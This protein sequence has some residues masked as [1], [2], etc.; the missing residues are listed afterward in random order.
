MPVGYKHRRWQA[1]L[2]ISASGPEFAPIFEEAGRA[3]RPRMA[4]DLRYTTADTDFLERHFREPNYDSGELEIHRRLR[5]PT[6]GDVGTALQDVLEWFRSHRDH[7][8]WDG[9]ALQLTF[10][11][12]GSEPDG[13]LVLADGELTP[14]YLIEESL[15]IAADASRSARLRLSLIL[16]SCHSGA[17][18]AKALEASLGNDVLVPF[19][20]VASCARDEFAWEESSL[21]HGIFTYCLSVRPNSLGSVSA[22]AIQANNSLGPSLSIAAGRFG[23]SLLTAGGQNPFYYLNGTGHIEVGGSEFSAFHEDGKP[24]ALEELEEQLLYHRESYAN[25]IRAIRPDLHM[26]RSSDAEMRRGIRRLR[27]ELQGESGSGIA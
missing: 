2:S 18:A 4:A 26:G 16:D 21:G 9:G 10:A 22:T 24:L 20:V 6:I 8:E 7:A 5:N 1:F 3:L 14:D 12:H 19:N 27:A 15:R 11:G 25:A 23:V 13:R 17:F